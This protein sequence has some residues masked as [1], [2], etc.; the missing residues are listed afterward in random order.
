MAY[1]V[2]INPLAEADIDEAY[3]WILRRSPQGARSWL[4]AILN[5]IEGLSE[6][7]TAYPVLAESEEV[8]Q[9]LRALVVFS[10][11]IIFRVVEIESRVDV[12]RVY[13]GARRPLEFW[14][15]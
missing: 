14:D 6:M 1:R 10:H 9:E 4:V 13:H 2:F 7:P 3:A 11:R 12:L 5:G 15:L 8:G